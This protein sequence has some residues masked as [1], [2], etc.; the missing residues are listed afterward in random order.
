MYGSRWPAPVLV[1]TGAVACIVGFVSPRLWKQLRSAR[2]VLA[3][4]GDAEPGS[5]EPGAGR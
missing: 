1:C 4:A 3:V 2:I 5:V